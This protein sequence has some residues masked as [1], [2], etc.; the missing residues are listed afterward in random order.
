MIPTDDQRMIY[1]SGNQMWRGDSSFKKVPAI[2][3]LPRSYLGGGPDVQTAAML[4][5]SIRPAT[6]SA[7]TEMT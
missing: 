6:R 4:P 1:H 5:R 3:S 7:E 2:A